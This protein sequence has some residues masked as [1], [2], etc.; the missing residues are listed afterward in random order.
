MW[1]HAVAQAQ[2]DGSF[3]VGEPSIRYRI[4]AGGWVQNGPAASSRKV[5]A[6]YFAARVWCSIRAW[7]AWRMRPAC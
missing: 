6:P 5:E 3:R 4:E 2:P 7:T 1:P